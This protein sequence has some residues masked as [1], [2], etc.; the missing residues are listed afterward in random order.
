MSLC[1]PL[2]LMERGIIENRNTTH[3]FPHRSKMFQTLTHIREVVFRK[4]ATSVAL[5]RC[6]NMA[7]ERWEF[8]GDRQR[9]LSSSNKYSHSTLG[10]QEYLYHKPAY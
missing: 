3:C 4:K 2:Q 1:Y 7:S 6:K 9:V 8:S 5:Q 10:S